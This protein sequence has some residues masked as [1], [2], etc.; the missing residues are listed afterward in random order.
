MAGETEWP[1]GK[2]NKAALLMKPPCQF[3]EETQAGRIAHGVWIRRL[4]DRHAEQDAL[5]RQLHLLAAQR[6]RYLGNR[7]NLVREVAGGKSGA[8]RRPDL[9]GQPFVKFHTWARNDEEWQVG[10]PAQPFK[11]DHQTVQYLRQFLNH[12]I[13]L[14]GPHPDPLPVDRRVRPPIDDHA[15]VRSHLDPIPVTPGSRKHFKVALA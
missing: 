14:A 2:P 13:E 12:S 8:N 4:L 10:W 6:P 11:V 3:H 7:E 1:S 5:D 15:P 9:L